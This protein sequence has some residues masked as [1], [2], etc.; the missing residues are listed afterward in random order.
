MQHF[1][2]EF[3]RI[4]YRAL[5]GHSSI[6]VSIQT[7]GVS[8]ISDPSKVETFTFDTIANAFPTTFFSK[9]SVTPNIQLT[10]DIV[11]D[12]ATLTITHIYPTGKS[13]IL[14]EEKL[15][16]HSG[17][18]ESSLFPI[19]NQEG[20]YV[21]SVRFKN[22]FSIHNA[23]WWGNLPI[24]TSPSFLV[25]ITAF[26]RDE[27]VI[28]L[29]QDLCRYEPLRNL[30]ISFLVVDNGQTL[31]REQL[32]DDPRIRFIS[33]TN[34]GCTSGVMRGLVVSRSLKTDF[35]IIADD[36]IV[37]PA[38]TLYRMVIFQMLANK[39]ISVG[40]GMITIRHPNIL[41]EQGSKV[42]DDGINS[43]KPFNKGIDLDS[44]SQY[45]RIFSEN[46]LEYTALWLMSAPTDQLS[47]LPAFFIYYEDILQGLMLGKKGVRIIVPPHIFLWHATLE[48]QAAF[49]K[50]YLWLRNDLTTRFL[51]EEKLKPTKIALSFFKLMMGFMSSYD[52]K[53]ARRHLQ[54][55]KEA[56]SGPEWTKDPISQ[57][58][59]VQTLIQ[60]NPAV[61]DLSDQLSPVFEEQL[62]KK[63]PLLY[64]MIRRIT[65][66]LTL[67]NYLNPACRPLTIDGKLAFRFHGDYEGWGWSGYKQIATIDRNKK[68]YIC[69]RSWKEMVP[70]MAETL[71]L[72]ILFMK[73]AEE[74]K[75]AYQMSLPSFESGWRNA[76]DVLDK[77]R[78]G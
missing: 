55:F 2:F 66:I 34:L 20:R 30:N 68:G 75:R 67:G 39:P 58:E 46:D 19:E 16:G 70:I 11:A 59:Y 27:Y 9:H 57:K 23:G 28:G 18:W 51:I 14:L 50:R 78:N 38:E 63:K 53:L 47:F 44:P 3:N 32:P 65:Y 21:L 45:S 5:W 52:Y 26:K 64:K 71:G 1:L 43:L 4:E 6:P 54:A 61:T 60:E 13:H 62:Q 31:S 8:G 40:A 42:P 22:G 72:M 37:M 7:D 48:K 36:D 25:S 35:M 56:I 49:W 41:W 12:D 29:L 74:N 17:P 15:C 24:K 73:T 76:F 77:K 33:Q 10:A 69:K